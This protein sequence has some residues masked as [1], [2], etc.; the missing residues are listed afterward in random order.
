MRERAPIINRRTMLVASGAGFA[1][2]AFGRPALSSAAVQCEAADGQI[3]DPV[4]SVR[5]G[6][7]H[8][9]LGHEARRARRLSRR[10]PPAPTSA[11]GFGSASI[12]RCWRGRPTIWRVVN[13]VGATVNTNDHHAGYYYNLTGHVPDPTLLAAGQQ[14]HAFPDDW[15]FM[16]SRG[17]VRAAAAPD[18][19]N[20]ITLPHKPS[21]APY[22]RPGQFAARLGIEHD[23]LY[24]HGSLEKPL[25]FQ[26]PGPD[27]GGDVDAGTPGDRRRACWRARRC[28]PRPRRRSPGTHWQR[29]QERAFTLLARRSTTAAFDV[30]ASRRAVRER[31]RRRRSTA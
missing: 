28:A 11:P 25:E 13:S 27:P 22:T 14:P 7:A 19:P 6:F 5:R 15:P 21:K 17:R 18:L 8:R 31:V 4:L 24:V 2:L 10:V 16:G 1:G 23:P 20:A 12:C 3:D 9:H 30:A 26:A 29:Q